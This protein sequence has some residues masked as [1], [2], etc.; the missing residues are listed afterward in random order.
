MVVTGDITQIDL[1]A[2]RGCGLLQ[3]ME[4]LKGID[5]IRFVNFD[6]RDVVRHS[7]VQKIVRAY[8]R[9]QEASGLNRQMTLRW[10]ESPAEKAP[11]P[12]ACTTSESD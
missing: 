10:S 8:D 7:L 3:A 4:V 6:E 2:G 12:A 11:E 1:P 5:E 9:Y